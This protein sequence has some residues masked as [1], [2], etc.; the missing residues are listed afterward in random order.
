MSEEKKTNLSSS[1]DRCNQRKEIEEA[2]VVWEHVGVKLRF[3]A[4]SGSDDMSLEELEL[5]SEKLLSAV[6]AITGERASHECRETE[7]PARNHS[8]IIPEK[9]YFKIGE[10]SEILNVEPYVLRYW[11]SDFRLLKPT[12]SRARQ[13]LYRKKDVE[14]LEL[15]RHLIY[16]EKF[17]MSGAKK[18]LVEL[19]KQKVN[20]VKVLSS[21]EKINQIS[22]EQQVTSE[23]VHAHADQLDY[24]KL[25]LEIMQML[26]EV[27]EK[28]ES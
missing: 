24:G 1:N 18:R 27:K 6:K 25:L 2:L 19:K 17:T 20:R 12:K 28:L 10:V 21:A 9:Q 23:S 3:M 4:A 22:A 8:I 13:R 16:D 14:K 15:I 11:E 5:E 7:A 26:K